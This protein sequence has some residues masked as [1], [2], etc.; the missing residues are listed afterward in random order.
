MRLARR[1]FIKTAGATGLALAAAPAMASGRSRINR[2]ALVRRHNPVAR[3]F[4]PF[5]ALTVGNGEFAYTADIT[6]LQT[7]TAR[8]DKLFPLCTTAHWSWHTTSA[9]AGIRREDLRYRDFDTYGRAVGYATD[10]AGQEPLFDWLRE[11]PHRLHLGRL[12]LELVKLDGAL[13]SPEDLN[14]CRQVLDLWTGVLDS[15][16][17]FLGKSIRVQTCCHPGMDLLAVCIESPLIG[18]GALRVVLAFPCGSPE[19]SMAVWDAPARHTTKLTHRS[20]RRAD[21]ERR[22]D[23]SVYFAGLEWSRG[24]ALSDV[25]AHEYRLLAIG[26]N[27]KATRLEFTC[28]FAPTP[29]VDKLPSFAQTLSASESGW[30]QFWNEGGAVDL[31]GCIDPQAVELD[32]RMVLSLY[33]TAVHCAG[34]LPPAETGLLFNSWYGKFHLEMHW[35]HCVHFAA[36]NRFSKFERSL[37]IY[38]RLLPLA[39]ETARR[40]G[41]RG[42]RWPKMIGP[43][44]HDS[45]STVGPLLIWQQPHPIYY[46]ELCYK[47]APSKKTL[48]HW[49]EVVF[50]T[51][52]FMASFAVLVPARNQ[53]VLGPTLKTVSENTD[54]VASTNPAFELAYWRFGLRV[55]QNWRER[56]GLE[57]EASWDRVLNRLAP[58]PVADGLYLMQESLADTY[59]TWNWEHPALVGALGML[60]GDGVDETLMRRS[61]ARVMEVWQWDRAWGWDFG[62]AA[63]C[64]ARTGQPELAVGALLVNSVK[65]HYLPNGHNYQRADLPAYLPGNGALL[66][67]LAMMCTG[68]SNGTGVSAPGFPSNGKWRVQQERLK[69]WI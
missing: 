26:S 68:W 28:A 49:R 31:S 57:R 27:P 30:G 42:A 8:C 61:L 38:Q 25:K 60:P 59:A 37:A 39:R 66:S 44:G 19:M 54:A 20:D 4:A 41:Y 55:A 11:N 14:N 56:L 7:F 33:N 29:V 32:R 1:D 6:G 2:Q 65:N 16:F 47:N 69:Q 22:L 18:S 51:A 35:W 24:F 34:S 48:E 52:D 67:A 40:Q 3:G 53:F 36:W 43:D 64:A 63:M 10:R 62:N 17:E 12:G 13:A 50:D 58:L 46:A 45:P 23:D 15:R 5:S 21:F 9:P